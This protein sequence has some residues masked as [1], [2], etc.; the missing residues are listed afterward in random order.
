[1]DV[2]MDGLTVE[3]EIEPR[4]PLFGGWKATFVIGYSVPL[5][6]F[7]FKSPDGQPYL[8]FSFGCPLHETLVDHQTIR[9]PREQGNYW[10]DEFRV[11]LIGLYFS[12]NA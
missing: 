12:I 3:L 11:S 4:Y 6:D 7:L 10:S 9:V 2:P 1:M 5:E 8:D